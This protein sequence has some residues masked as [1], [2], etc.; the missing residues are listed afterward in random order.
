MSAKV[1][2]HVYY[3]G[4]Q[5]L[6]AMLDVFRMEDVNIVDFKTMAVKLPMA[7]HFEGSKNDACAYLKVISNNEALMEEFG[8]IFDAMKEEFTVSED[9]LSVLRF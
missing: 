9:V 3:C 4:P 6:R 5:L 2:T 7:G 1:E 8:V